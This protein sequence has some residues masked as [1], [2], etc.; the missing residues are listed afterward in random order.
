VTVLLVLIVGVVV[1]FR[2]T[3][4][5]DRARYLAIAKACIRRR[6]ESSKQGRPECDAFR[7]ALRER[8]PRPF[9]TIVCAALIVGA[10]ASPNGLETW[11][12]A[13]LKT[14]NGEWWRLA[15][16]VFVH[17]NV[18]LLLLNVLILLQLGFVVERLV[19]P[20]AFAVTF[21]GSG[22]VASVVHLSKEP[23]VAGAGASGAIF[24]LYGLLIGAI[25]WGWWK[26]SSVTIPRAT[27]NTMGVS[28]LLFAIVS[29]F[30]GSLTSAAELTAL[31]VGTLAGAVLARFVDEHEPP[32]Q[33][34]MM[35]AG[36]AAVLAF[37]WAV[38][39]RG[40]SDVRPE[41]Q[42][43]VS[44]EEKTAGAYHAAAEQFRKGRVTAEAVAQLIERT[45][46][47]ELQAADARLK[48]YKKVPPEH[49]PLIVDAEEYLRL[50]SE[51]WRLRATAVRKT[52]T[53][54]RRDAEKPTTD[55]N[56]RVKAEARHHANLVLLGNAES[57]ERTSLEALQK[58]S[59]D[60]RLAR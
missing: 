31:L 39:L 42:R 28:G 23:L 58:V 57:S 46:V 45:I 11:A 49:Q 3:T 27:L 50:R 54:P 55:E 25:G 12:N 1:G 14:T 41:I 15:T 33:H 44:I 24:G 34:V 21:L 29:L 32:P 26:P 51:S 56:W 6:K 13:G 7:A 4:S 53:V 5:E 40:I 36:A 10:A 60:I 30:T 22:V 43:V 35:V 59:S 18:I 16:A 20:G 2:L 52:T 47:P 37:A 8:T 17:T 38:P 9:V 19:G 48:T